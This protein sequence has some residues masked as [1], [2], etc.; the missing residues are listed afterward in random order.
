MGLAK[1]LS[2]KPMIEMEETFKKQQFI[3]DS[4]NLETFVQEKQQ[5]L[6]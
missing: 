6:K 2:Q 5:N 4:R 3:K 1:S